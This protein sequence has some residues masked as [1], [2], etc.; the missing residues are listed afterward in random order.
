MKTL[1]LLLPLLVAGGCIYI[2]EPGRLPD[3]DNG[4]RITKPMP[5]HKTQPR[6]PHH[7]QN[8][9]NMEAHLI[10]SADGKCLDHS[11]SGYKGIITYPCHGENNQ[12][13]TFSRN[14]IMVE[15]LCLDIAGERNDDGTPVIAYTCHGNKNQQWYQDGK[16][17]RS[18]LNGKCLD[19][20]KHGN[21]IRMY[22]CDGSLGQRF[23][24]SRY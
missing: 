2:E 9:N 12:Q 6:A 23:D 24:I 15:G 11:R 13:F 19:A 4:I 10:R 3:T 18:A 17:I 21:Q 8:S 20:G 5:E 7:T 14:R 1:L 22:R 16:T